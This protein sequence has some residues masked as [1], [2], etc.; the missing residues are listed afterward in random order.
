MGAAMST[1]PTLF[2]SKSMS[3]DV[4]DTSHWDG[5]DANAGQSQCQMLVQRFPR[6]QSVSVGSDGAVT[7]QPTW[8]AKTPTNCTLNPKDSSAATVLGAGYYVT[9]LSTSQITV[10]AMATHTAAGSA[11]AMVFY[12]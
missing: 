10:Q 5:A 1:T 8:G 2:S 4:G 6:T 9:Q 7:F 12:E 3:N 11:Y